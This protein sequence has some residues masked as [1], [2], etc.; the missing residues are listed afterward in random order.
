MMNTPRTSITRLLTIAVLLVAA[1]LSAQKQPLDHDT[2]D[3]WKSIEGERISHDGSWVLYNLTVRRGDAELVVKQPAGTEH[4]VARATDARFSPDERFAVFTIEPAYDTVRTLRLADT[5]RS[6]LPEDTLGI[7]TLATGDVARVPGVERWTLPEESGAIVVYL[8]SAEDAEES[9]EEAEETEE[10]AEEPAE[11][12]EEKRDK[13]DTYTLV[14]RDLESGAEQRYDHV[15]DYAVSEDGGVVTYTASSEDGEADGVYVVTT[16]SGESTAVLAGEGLYKQLALSDDGRRVAFLTDR[17][18]FHAD[19]PEYILYHAPDG[20]PAEALASSETDGVPE[21]WWVSEHGALSFSESGN[22]LFFGTAPRPEPEDEDEEELLD[23]EKV[24]LDVWHWQDDLIQPMQ[25]LQADRERERTYAAVVHLD[26]RNRVVQLANEDMPSVDVGRE[27]DADVAL[28]ETNVKYLYLVGIE[29]PGYSDVWLVDVNDGDRRMVLEEERIA[30]GH[31]S[32][33]ARYFAFYDYDDRAWFAMETDDDEP[34]NLS[35][36]IDV[37]VWDETDDHPMAPY[38]H[39]S[40]GWTEG[41]G[42]LL[43]YDRFDIWAVDPDGRD[44][45]RRITEGWGRENDV[46]FRYIRLDDDE[47]FIDP[48]AP[49]LL[50]AFHIYTKDAGFYRDRVEGTAEPEALVR[51]PKRFGSLERAEAADVLLYTRE[52][53]VEFPDLWVADA[54]FGNARKISDAN[55]QQAEYNWATVELVEWLSSNGEELQ[56]LLYKP[57]DFDPS[58]EY[59]MMVY[60]YE[61]SSDNLHAHAPPV[62]HRSV[63]RP[64]FYASRGYIVFIPD[65]VYQEGFPGESAMDCIMPGT[66]KLAEESWVDEENVGVQGH[67]WG[68]YQI[69]YMV[70]QT[71]FFKAAEA[72][73]PVSNMTSAY[74]GIRWGSGMS[75]MFQYERTQSRIGGT[76]WDRPIRY[77]ENSPLFFLDKVETPLLIMHNDEDG[78]VPWYQGIELFVALRRLAKPAWMIVYNEQ[79]HWPVTEANMRDWNVRMQQFF[80]HYLKGAPAPVWLEEGIPATEKGETLGLEPAEEAGETR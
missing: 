76:L 69:A 63:I 78:A 29:S 2:Y 25:V 60:F 20:E 44:A 70:T 46:R 17:D 39:G 21:G 72:G 67:S 38:P 16:A 4:R 73:A 66:L 80:D 68:G 6:E 9:A 11:E 19:Q 12:E 53:V 43:I 51:A 42:T 13:P 22:R 27:G 37:P 71:D 33:D 14:I 26:R 34:V 5:K 32:P 3:I 77:I 36:G 57:E 7:L 30:W 40:A 45:P 61:K 64:T 62:P 79:P 58:Q 31:L 8:I 55:P 41:D 75:R 1:P 59:P 18:S 56:G 35:A 54:E 49:M 48:D 24:R 52:D 10:V 23:E 74:G 50:S 15:V 65:I 28:A 47:R